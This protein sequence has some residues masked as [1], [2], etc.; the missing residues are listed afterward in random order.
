MLDFMVFY[1]DFKD[2]MSLDKFLTELEKI[3]GVAQ[4]YDVNMYL[5]TKKIYLSDFENLDLDEMCKVTYKAVDENLICVVFYNYTGEAKAFFDKNNVEH[6]AK[7]KHQ[8]MV[9]ETFNECMCKCF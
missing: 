3:G 6:D 7:V 4:D 8:Y 2:K 9:Q 5:G 1:G